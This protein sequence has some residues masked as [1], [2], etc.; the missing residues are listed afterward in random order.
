M[1]FLAFWKPALSS[2]IQPPRITSIDIFSVPELGLK[3]SFDAATDQLSFFTNVHNI[4]AVK[5]ET[6]TDVFSFTKCKASFNFTL[7]LDMSND[8]IAAGYF[9]NVGTW[10]TQILNADDT[11]ALYLEGGLVSYRD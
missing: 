8:G 2:A 7:A 11:E 10:S 4:A 9:K 1:T 3:S 6:E 5:V